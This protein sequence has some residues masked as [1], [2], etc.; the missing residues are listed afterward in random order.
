MKI[1]NYIFIIL[2]S[3]SFLTAKSFDTQKYLN[4]IHKPKSTSG[5]KILPHLPPINQ[6]TTSACWSFATVSFIESEMQRFGLDTVRLSVMYPFFHV[7]IEKARRF[8]ETRGES[9]FSPGDL[10]TGVFD[11]VQK[12]GIVPYSV[13]PGLVNG[14]KTYNHKRMY[15]Q[16]DS[17]MDQVKILQVWNEDLVLQKVREILYRFMGVPPQSF[18]YRGRSYSPKT[19][20]KEVVRLP[21][22][23]YIMVTSFEYAPFYRFTELKVPDNWAHNDRYF[24]VPLNDFYRGIKN[25]L[26]RGYSV[27]FD[28]DIGEPG[29]IGKYDVSFVPPY[30]IPGKYIDQQAREMRFQNGSTTDDHLM[31]F[32]GYRRIGGDDWF[33]VKDS[34]R[35]AW[36]GKVPG[37]FFFHGDYVKLKVL[38]FLVHKKAVPEIVKNI[39]LNPNSR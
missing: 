2:V 23:Q 6:D 15:A 26:K 19:F 22:D 7:Y 34:W 20:L 11:M 36:D 4:K 39:K 25:A 32:V 30:D 9:R 16:L 18:T 38:A 29:R 1:R 5:F 27:A 37:Y 28:S 12:Y 17:L 10:F 24:N 33:L 8:V 31:H 3:V 35:T 21:W 14:R 13:Y